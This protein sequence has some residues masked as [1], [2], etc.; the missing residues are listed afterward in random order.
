MRITQPFRSDDRGDTA[1][2]QTRSVRKTRGNTL[3][4]LSSDVDMQYPAARSK[5]VKISLLQAVQ[6]PRV[7]RG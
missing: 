4:N 6:A 7:A 5:K 1:D 3:L 2:D